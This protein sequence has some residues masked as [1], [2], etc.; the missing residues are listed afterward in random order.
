MNDAT[1]TTAG[2]LPLELAG[3]SLARGGKQVLKDIDCRIEAAPARTSASKATKQVAKKAP[4][5]KASGRT[6]RRS[7]R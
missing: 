4:R 7:G 3:V 6:A 2:I 5:K 1:V